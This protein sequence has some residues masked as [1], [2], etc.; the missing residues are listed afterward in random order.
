MFKKKLQPLSDDDKAYIVLVF[1][2]NKGETAFK[3]LE[4]DEVTNL[5]SSTTQY[6][7]INFLEFYLLY[8]NN[9]QFANKIND[10][11]GQLNIVLKNLLLTPKL[12][13]RLGYVYINTR[14]NLDDKD[15]KELLHKWTSKYSDLDAVFP[16]DKEALD[17][18]VSNIVPAVQIHEAV[19]QNEIEVDGN[20][21]G[22]VFDNVFD[23]REL[24][25]QYMGF[26]NLS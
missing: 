18:W 6:T 11:A 12:L 10:F 4:P 2:E 7:L 16:S 21:A 3:G 25:K 14:P 15:K 1:L 20:Y 24:T 17:S 23:N 9:T 22:L 5:I 19:V 26:R 13:I 8:R